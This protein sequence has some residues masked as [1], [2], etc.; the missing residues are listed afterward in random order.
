MFQCRHLRHRRRSCLLRPLLSCCSRRQGWCRSWVV[1][2]WSCSCRGQALSLQPCQQ[3]RLWS[4]SGSFRPQFRRS[5]WQH[6]L[7]N[8]QWWIRRCRQPLFRSWL[9]RSL[10]HSWWS[11]VSR[12]RC[13]LW[14]SQKPALPQYH[15]QLLWPLCCTPMS[16]FHWSYWSSFRWWVQSQWSC[17]LRVRGRRS[18][19]S[20]L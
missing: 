5:S 8:P 10:W 18:R 7:Q 11:S 6:F 20:R 13:H 2:L 1:S 19:H 12:I 4:W 14:M 16:L 9:L 17:I 15:L 3:R